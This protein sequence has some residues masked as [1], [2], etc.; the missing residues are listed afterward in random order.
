MTT[1]MNVAELDDLEVNAKA[2]AHQ[3]GEDCHRFGAKVVL[4][5]IEEVRARD[6]VARERAKLAN[7]E[8]VRAD[9][10]ERKLA[11]TQR[12][13]KAI[14]PESQ[15][16]GELNTSVRVL[17]NEL[18]EAVI[19]AQEAEEDLAA[20]N[21]EVT[22]L[23]EAL[24]RTEFVDDDRTPLAVRRLLEAQNTIKTYEKVLTAIATA[25]KN[26]HTLR[27]MARDALPKG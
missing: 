27:A 25:D 17:R 12:N 2:A 9:E 4:R 1:L 21:E 8:R 7:Q 11:D 16:I 26:A 22:K 18:H 6:L 20:R 3:F 15:T 19:R 5:L 14:E 23:H 24:D 10:A 13:A